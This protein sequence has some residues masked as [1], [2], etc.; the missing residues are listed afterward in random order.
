MLHTVGQKEP[1]L[2]EA[3]SGFRKG[4]GTADV[5]RKPPSLV[6]A[7]VRHQLHTTTD[8][9]IQTNCSRRLHKRILLG[10]ARS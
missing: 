2:H 4:S 3:Q 10:M 6:N 1:Q 9:V 8:E 7:V 5:M